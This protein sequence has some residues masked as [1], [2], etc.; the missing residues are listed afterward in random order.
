MADQPNIVLICVDQWRGDCLSIDGHPTVR[1]PALDDLANRGAHFRRAYSATPSC[2]PARVALMTGLSQES[3]RRVGYVDGVDFDITTTMAGQFRQA[4]YQTKAIGKMHVHPGRARV[5][6]DDVLLHDGYM[7]YSHKRSRAAEEFDD[8]LPW[9]RSQPGQPQDADFADTGVNPNS[10]V[11]RPWDKP[12]ALH[13]TNWVITQANSWLYRRDPTVPFFLYLS[14]YYPHPPYNP[15]EWALNQYLDAP[16]ED[17]ALGD[18]WRDYAEFQ[19][20]FNITTPLAELPPQVRD[21]ARAGYYGNIAH[22]DTQITRF[23]EMLNAFDLDD[24]T[25]IA[26]TADHGEMLGD[27]NMYRKA[28]PYEG[29][30]RVPFIL[31]PPKRSAVIE[32]G[33][34]ND[35]VVELRDVMPTLLDCAGI[36]IPE[37]VEGRSVLP[38]ARGQVDVPWREY[39]HGEHA[40]FA[41]SLQWVTDGREKYCWL[42]GS[43]TEH[44]FDLTQ[45]P[46]EERNLAED[47]AYE[48]RLT[49]WRSIL[50]SELTGREEGY[51]DNG[52]LMPGRPPQT[53]LSAPHARNTPS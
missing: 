11:A 32:A 1:T 8:Y 53:L 13:P 3:H 21:R 45:D 44:L 20:D 47:L 17:P 18:W 38:W 52:Q 31:T 34:A 12:E 14:F 10:V 43:G 51:V 5:G 6:F 27:H 16:M 4:G 9:L 41:Q 40:W 42:S 24:N 22:I 36:D 15:P 26:F 50:I 29:S 39:I 2:V 7:H 48:D 37:Q 49:H 33:V 30:A 35:A 46:R 23:V 19:D 28:V 25:Y